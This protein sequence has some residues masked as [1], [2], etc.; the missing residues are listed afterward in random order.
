M[1]TKSSCSLFLSVYVTLCLERLNIRILDS[2]GRIH[3]AN[4]LSPLANK[5]MR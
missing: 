4:P 3:A 1:L 5:T 2:Y